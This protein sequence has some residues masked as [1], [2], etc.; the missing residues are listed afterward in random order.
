MKLDIGE[1]FDSII[2]GTK[3]VGKAVHTKTSEFHEKYVSKVLPKCG[4]YGEAATFLAEMAPGVTEYNAIKDGDWKA[5]AIAAGIDVAAVVAGT[6]T[7]GTGFTAVKGGSNVAKNGVKRAVREITEAG[8]G[9]AVKEVT[10]A[11]TK[12]KVGEIAETSTEKAV[13]EVVKVGTEKT[14]KEVTEAETE[15]SVKEV[16]E[17]VGNT[18][19][20][21]MECRNQGLEGFRHPETGVE[22]V[23]KIVGDGELIEGVFP[24]FKSIFNAKLSPELLKE[25]NVKQFKEANWQLLES[26]DHNPSL[27]RKFTMEQME[28]IKDGCKDGRAPDGFVWHHNEE[29]GILQ[30]V[31]QEIHAITGHTGGRSI[32]GGGY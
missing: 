32:W 15:K 12:K 22:F 17:H 19:V 6:F 11:G 26:I 20:R 21:Y 1:T 23:R 2:D 28:Q 8:T 16:I 29:T 10:E 14:V 5:F 9:K 31:D 27:R 30:L 13:K 4:K 18:I 24:K 7:A 3:E 25:N